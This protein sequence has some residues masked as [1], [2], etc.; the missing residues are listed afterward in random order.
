MQKLLFLLLILV[1][2]AVTVQATTYSCRDKQGKLFM[3]DNLQTL[4]DECWGRA[5]VVESKDP[6][7]LHYVPPHSL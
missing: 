5:R 4:P 7:N 6:D 2:S 1:F 3:T